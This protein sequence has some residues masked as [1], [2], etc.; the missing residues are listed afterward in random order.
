M[1]TRLRRVFKSVTVGHCNLSSPSSKILSSTSA[2]CV[3]EEPDGPG[4]GSAISEFMSDK[5]R[6]LAFMLLSSVVSSSSKSSSLLQDHKNNEIFS[7][8]YT[9]KVKKKEKDLM[10]VL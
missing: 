4:D 8:E 5:S 9:L 2:G 10:T 7:Q 6:F 3:S 1:I